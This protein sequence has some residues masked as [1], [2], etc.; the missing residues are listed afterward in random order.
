MIVARCAVETLA[1]R[2]I[3]SSTRFSHSAR[4]KRALA[5]GAAE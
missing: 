1:P 4:V 2:A 5:I 3:M